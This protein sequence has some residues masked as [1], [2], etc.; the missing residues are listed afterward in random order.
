MVQ[1]EASPQNAQKLVCWN[2]VTTVVQLFPWD[3]IDDDE[4]DEAG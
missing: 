2:V 1:G 3:G 4:D